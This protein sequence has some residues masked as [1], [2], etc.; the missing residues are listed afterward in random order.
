MTSY[1]QA[2][3]ALMDIDHFQ[4]LVAAIPFEDIAAPIPYWRQPSNPLENYSLAPIWGTSNRR[5][6]RMQSM[7]L[8][9]YNN[10]TVDGITIEYWETGLGKPYSFCHLNNRRGM[11]LTHDQ[12]DGRHGVA[13][14]AAGIAPNS[15]QDAPARL[16]I[17]QLQGLV[18]NDKQPNL[19]SALRS[20]FF[21]R[22]AFVR[23]W[24]S[25]AENIPSIGSIA[26]YSY[27]ETGT[28]DE[29]AE[30]FKKGYD[31]VAD[32]QGYDFHEQSSL[33]IKNIR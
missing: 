5:G 30:H 32:R 12:N 13:V 1:E 31:D 22:D 4:A 19:A 28:P 24:E 14:T 26:I 6:R 3:S 16:V 20:G 10:R 17:T 25:L 11:V 33:W 29:L 18:R 9:G 27:T 8:V 2:E 15:P 23:A 7:D 21:W